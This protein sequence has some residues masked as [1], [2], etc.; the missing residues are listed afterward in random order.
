MR[1]KEKHEVDFVITKENTPIALIEAK[2]SDD[3]LSGGLKYF[4]ERVPVPHVMQLVAHLREPKQYGAAK[5]L[6]AL[7]FLT[8]PFDW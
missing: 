1:D 2:L 8:H 6:P 3:R 4:A 7:D 5:V